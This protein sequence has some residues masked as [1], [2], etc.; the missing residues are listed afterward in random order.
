VTAFRLLAADEDT[1]ARRGVLTTAHGEVQTPAFM[2]V[3]TQGTVKALAPRDLRELGVDIV[4]ANTYHLMIRPGADI[5]RGL[6][7]L[8]RFMG[9][10][11]PILTDSGGY[12]VFSLAPLRTIRDDG[13]AFQSHVDGASCFLGPREAMA[14]QADLGSD[15]AMVF[16]ECTPWPCDRET[17]CAAV[18]RSLAWAALCRESP[19]PE[20]QLLFGIVQGALYPELRERCARDLVGMGFDG[21]AVGGLSVGEPEE[22]M[23]DGLDMALPWLPDDRARYLMGAGTPGQIVQCVARGVDMFDCVLPTRVARN[24][25]AYTA[26]GLLPVKAGRFKD[27][28][29]PVEADCGCATC[30]SFS[31]GYIRHLLNA[32]EILGLRLLTIHNVHF[33]MKLMR[34][35]RDAIEERRFKAFARTFEQEGQAG[36]LLRER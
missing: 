24:G 15:I 6:G 29:G 1:A 13:V 26:A 36:P 22:Q 9:W 17:A 35:I 32:G 21:Y 28:P 20:G 11:G 33:Y 7:G 2:P 16:D 4:L 14:I 30:R 8:H 25:S 3:G 19:R 23:Y 10:D 27:D 34:A 12:Q 31:R 5:I 18:D